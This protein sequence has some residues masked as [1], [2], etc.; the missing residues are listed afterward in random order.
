MITGDECIS[1]RFGNAGEDDLVLRVTDVSIA[2][3]RETRD[4][5]RIRPQQIQELLN[6]FVL[7]LVAPADTRMRHRRPNLPHD[8]GT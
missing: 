4:Y 1:T 7:N 2:Y 5:R 6:G 8:G 3:V